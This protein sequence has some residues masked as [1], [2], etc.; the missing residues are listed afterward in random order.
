MALLAKIAFD[1]SAKGFG[2][3]WLGERIIA[4]Y[5]KAKQLLRPGACAVGR[6]GRTVATDA[7]HVLRAIPAESK[8][9]VSAIFLPTHPEALNNRIGN[10]APRRKCSDSS[11]RDLG[12]GHLR[13][14]GISS[15]RVLAHGHST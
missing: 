12:N 6:P 3:N 14:T 5:G 8:I 1:L 13:T 7:A 10:V 4:T 9:I 2:W 15:Q 11:H